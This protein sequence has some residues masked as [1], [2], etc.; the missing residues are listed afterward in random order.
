MNRR[1]ILAAGV[2][3]PEG[4]STLTFDAAPGP[5]YSFHMTPEPPVFT[6]KLADLPGNVV[7][8]CVFRDSIIIATDQCS[9]YEIKNIDV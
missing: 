8:M 7:S 1:Q 2:A 4:V 6:R 5:S 9:I 3:A